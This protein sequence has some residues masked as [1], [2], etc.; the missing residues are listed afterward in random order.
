MYLPQACLFDL[1]GVLLDTEELHSEAWSK[2]AA[3]YGIILTLDQLNSLRGKRRIECA[4]QIVNWGQSSVSINNFLD[5]HEPISKEL[6]SMSEAIPGAELLVKWCDDNNLP[7]AL[8][9]SSTSISVDHKTA[10]HDWINLIQT[11]V[12]GDDNFLQKG[13]PAPEPYLLATKKLGVIPGSCW[14]IEDSQAGVQSAL[15]AGC[16]VWFLNNDLKAI[17]KLEIGDLMQNLRQINHL[18]EVLEA[19]KEII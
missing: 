12:Y 6:I 14:A 18:T 5:T 4:E 2:S 15:D 7:M 9:T 11:R 3:E 16:Q 19:L 10:T 1:D 13:K 17:S 8:V